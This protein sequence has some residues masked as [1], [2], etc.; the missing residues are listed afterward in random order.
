MSSQLPLSSNMLTIFCWI[1]G[2][3]GA[4]P[5]SV[6]GDQSVYEVKKAIVSKSPHSF[7]EI[8]TRNLVLWRMDVE[9]KQKKN[10][11]ESRLH[12]QDPLDDVDEIGVYFNGNP[13]KQHIHII[14]KPP[15][16][17]GICFLTT[18]IC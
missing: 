4:F 17:Y 15:G 6:R 1:L 13:P 18:H 2:A 8:D 10:F 3:D 11:Q 5:V 14:I 16:M 12:N 9:S 7:Q